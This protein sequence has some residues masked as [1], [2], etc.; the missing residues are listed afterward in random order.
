VAPVNRCLRASLAG[1]NGPVPCRRCVL[2]PRG[3]SAEAATP[4]RWH[5]RSAKS[6]PVSP[7]ARMALG[8]SDYLAQY[9][10]AVVSPFSQ[11]VSYG[12]AHTR[13]AL[14]SAS[15]VSN[16]HGALTIFS[17]PEHMTMS[18]TPSHSLRAPPSP[19][20]QLPLVSFSGRARLRSVPGE[21]G[22]LVGSNQRTALCA[23]HQEAARWLKASAQGAAGDPSAA[24]RL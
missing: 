13:Q 2:S 17:A 6:I 10:S 3:R 19:N 20:G 15:Y 7:Q 23:L 12:V 22:S 14:G 1:A 18:V 4:L 9:Q 21:P 24:A 16:I 11:S 5:P 8:L